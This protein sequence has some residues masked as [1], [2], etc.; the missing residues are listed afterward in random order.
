MTKGYVLPLFLV[1]SACA[2]TPQQIEEPQTVRQL[3]QKPHNAFDQPLAREE[4]L[5]F[6]ISDTNVTASVITDSDEEQ[7]FSS[8]CLIETHQTNNL[9]TTDE[10]ARHLKSTLTR[11]W[12]RPGNINRQYQCSVQLYLAPSGCV[13]EIDVLGCKD[14]AQLVRSIEMA[15]FRSAPLPQMRGLVDGNSLSFEFF[16][17]P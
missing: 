7:E 12:I 5:V 2:S 10:L 4:E 13:S 16:A 3:Q 11:K 15:L 8:R 17:G 1:L 9:N 14:N 6:S